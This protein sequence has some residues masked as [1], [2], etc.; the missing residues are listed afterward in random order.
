MDHDAAVLSFLRVLVLVPAKKALWLLVD[1]LKVQLVALS[2]CV[3]CSLVRL[4]CLEES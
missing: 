3:L 1:Q 2:L 4:L